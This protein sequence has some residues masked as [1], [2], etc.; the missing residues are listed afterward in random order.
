M[1]ISLLITINYCE[2]PLKSLLN[3]ITY[4]EPPLKSLLNTTKITIKHQCH[5]HWVHFTPSPGLLH[6]S[7][8]SPAPSA[9]PSPSHLIGGGCGIVAQHPRFA[10]AE[11]TRGRL[12]GWSQWDQNIPWLDRFDWAFGPWETPLQKRGNSYEM[13]WQSSWICLYMCMFHRKLKFFFGNMFCF[14]D[15]DRSWSSQR[16]TAGFDLGTPKLYNI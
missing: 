13:F 6:P 1:Y 15:H 8:P 9:S 2:P 10:V 7:Y 11:S 3:I 16:Y 4:C 12:A 14:V 5:H